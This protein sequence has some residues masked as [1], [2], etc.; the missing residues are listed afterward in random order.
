[1]RS[2]TILLL[3]IA[4]LVAWDI[5]DKVRIALSWRLARRHIDRWV[6]WRAR[7]LF[8][9]AHLMTG[10]RLAVEIHHNSLPQRMVIVA[11]HQSVIDIVALLASFRRH[12]IRFVAKAE[13]GRGF[14]AVSRVLR[15]QRHALIHRTGDFGTA[16]RR[17]ERLGR[18][19]VGN[20]SVVIF[21]EGTRSRTGELGEFHS[22]AI[23]R[24]LSAQPLPIV[25]VAVDGGWQFG[26]LA[27]VSKLPRGFV[28]RARAVGTW[29]APR[30]K[31]ELTAVLGEAHARIAATL[32]DWR[33]TAG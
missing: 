23:R 15:V 19:L 2:L 1:M 21:P 20:E 3:L 27:A 4:Q 5:A 10:I 17:I 29:P 16:M 12:S 22:G 6:S 9:I 32:A 30:G 24:L 26:T 14:P 25:A 11:N 33:S 7:R 28:Y 13:L 8:A 31:H 18:S